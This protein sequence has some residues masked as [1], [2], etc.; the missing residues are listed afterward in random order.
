[1]ES[2][3]AL[4]LDRDGIINI[5]KSYVFEFEN[6]EFCEG[7]IPLIQWAN[8]KNLYVIVVTNQSGVARGY[9][10]EDNVIK[11]HQQMNDHLTKENAHVD[12]WIFSTYHPKAIKP[13]H[14]KNPHMRKPLDGMIQEALKQFPIDLKSSIM[15]GD[16]LTDQ[17]KNDQ[18]KTYLVQGNYDLT[19]AESL[20][21]ENLSLFLEYLRSNQASE[22]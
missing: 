7:I 18:L 15:V 9:Y 12:S 1:M 21:F 20:V 6:I 13:E 10:N 4:F 14:F 16:K 3:G 19:G 5:D 8:K 17:I 22:S 2:K 11:L